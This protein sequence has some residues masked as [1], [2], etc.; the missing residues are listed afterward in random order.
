MMRTAFESNLNDFFYGETCSS[1]SPI[2]LK[3]SREVIS[4][5]PRNKFGK[6]FI[7]S[8]L[9]AGIIGASV[10]LGSSGNVTTKFSRAKEL[11]AHSTTK[12]YVLD[13]RTKEELI[14]V[15]LSIREAYRFTQ[16][17][18]ATLLGLSE[19]TISKFE[20]GEHSPDSRTLRKYTEFIS[21][22]DYLKVK[23]SD[24]K[25]AIRQLFHSESRVFGGLNSFEFSKKIGDDGF[26]E[27][28]SVLR[29]L[30]G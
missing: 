11:S 22:I 7:K 23:T 16:N 18:V 24:R 12:S 5:V 30:Y 4:N 13:D 19:S 14:E 3:E 9:V 6:V 21:L 10:A 2:P 25:F 29:R 17:E 8:R 1:E 20:R 26:M 27:V 28:S 15:F